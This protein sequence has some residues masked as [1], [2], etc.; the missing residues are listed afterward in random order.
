MTNYKRR[1]AHR[2]ND[3]Q[4]ALE[5][6]SILF[7]KARETLMQESDLAQSYVKLAREIGMRYKVRMPIE[8][9]RLICKKCK[10][11]TLPGMNCRVRTQRRREPHLVITCLNCGSQT[12][13]PLKKE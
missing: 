10:N 7:E 6:I 5:R 8:Y 13:I 9:R 4:I 12:R 2:R 1:A 3:R 11:F